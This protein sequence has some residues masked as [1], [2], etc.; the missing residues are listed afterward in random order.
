MRVFTRV[1][2]RELVRTHRL[3]RAAYTPAAVEAVKDLAAPRVKLAIAE[4]GARAYD[5]GRMKRATEMAH[6]TIGRGVVPL[7]PIRSSKYAKRYLQQ[8]RHSYI[9]LSE[10]ER[11]LE[12]KKFRLEQWG[13]QR[14]KEYRQ[15]LKNIA[16]IGK[17]LD[18]LSDNIRRVDAEPDAI[19][20]G[21]FGGANG[22]RRAKSPF[23]LS[24]VAQVVTKFYGGTT[25]VIPSG[26]TVR[27]VMTIREP[28]A[29]LVD[30]RT[31]IVSRAMLG[32]TSVGT[33]QAFR[34]YVN[35]F[36]HRGG[37]QRRGVNSA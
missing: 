24:N 19:V 5:T 10:I 27:F 12:K 28:H 9:R 16:R 30:R 18:R 6:N 21:G 1:D 17:V 32:A 26:N 36:R 20:I 34:R 35:E 2:T 13:R 25:T 33:R 7:T 23:A 22:R 3:S 14:S 11:R 4:I 29:F 37:W 31:K 8:F 15:T